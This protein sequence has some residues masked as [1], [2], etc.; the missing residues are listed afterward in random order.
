MLNIKEYINTF[1]ENP[2]HLSNVAKLC[3]QHLNINNI[4]PEIESGIDKINDNNL[5]IDNYMK[6]VKNTLNE[7][8]YGHEKAKRQIERIIGQWING[9]GSGYCF[10]FEGPPGVGKTPPLD[11]PSVGTARQQGVTFGAR[12]CDRK[13]C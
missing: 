5:I 11:H 3:N 7:S 13:T 4:L 8:V 1:K 6:S 12:V 10:G 2:F 9:N